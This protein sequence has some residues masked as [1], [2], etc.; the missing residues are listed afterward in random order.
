MMILVYS[1]QPPPPPTL[2][3]VVLNKHTHSVTE[4]QKQGSEGEDATLLSAGLRCYT[5]KSQPPFLNWAMLQTQRAESSHL[6]PYVSHNAAQGA[7]VDK[8]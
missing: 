5:T 8:G 1:H 6:L 7:V 2:C 4:A 3:C